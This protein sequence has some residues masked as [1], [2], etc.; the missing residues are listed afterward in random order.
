MIT[1]LLY[2]YLLA[3]GVQYG[4]HTIV[5]N[6]ECPRKLSN[7]HRMHHNIPS[8]ITWYGS[9]TIE[10]EFI[11]IYYIAF[12]L[13]VV[14]IFI[15][16]KN[17]ITHLL[18]FII[19]GSTFLIFHGLCHHLSREIQ[20]KIPILRTLF[21]HHYKHHIFKSKNLG[22]GDLLY[23]YIFGT[24]DLGPIVLNEKTKERIDEKYFVSNHCGPS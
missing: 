8:E 11:G 5:H 22:F 3:H 14:H 19:I 23:D 21:Y 12:I 15:F 24:L 18:S 17:I 4:L 1:T 2:H 10:S 13:Y 9:P 20:E 16:Y 7:E 6:K